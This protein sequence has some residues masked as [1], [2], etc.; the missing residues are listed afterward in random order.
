MKMLWLLLFLFT[1]K[2]SVALE[3]FS[4]EGIQGT[5]DFPAKAFVG[6]PIQLTL[7]LSYPSDYKWDEK[8]ALE[9][10]FTSLGYQPFPFQLIDKELSEA[11][12]NK[13]EIQQ[14]LTLTLNPIFPGSQTLT[15]YDLTFISK[16]DQITKLVEMPLSRI[17]VDMPAQA[18]DSL[19][20]P[21][22]L[23][24][25]KH[26]PVEINRSNE[27]LFDSPKA[28]S[29]ERSYNMARAA[30]KSFPILEIISLGL[31]AGFLWAALTFTTKRKPSVF[32][33]T[34]EAADLLSQI[35]KIDQEIPIDRFVGID[36]QLR[37]YIAQKYALQTKAL[38]D[39]EFFKLLQRQPTLQKDFLNT[40]Q[41][42]SDLAQ[43]I[44]FADYQPSGYEIKNLKDWIKQLIQDSDLQSPRN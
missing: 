34:K 37:K 31:V 12:E 13:K 33:F 11:I 23:I 8:K 43:K 16:D 17:L 7:T 19:K 3:T 24:F 15:F 10:L 6:H 4:K 26:I 35:K 32:D 42:Y 14:T 27:S 29:D 41:L 30:Y 9:N 40:F 38:T 44:K 28:L 22:P 36:S 2:Q 5:I 1:L 18:F 25:E 39:E 21:D 20:F